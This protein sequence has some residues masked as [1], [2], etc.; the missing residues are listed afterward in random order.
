MIALP[1]TGAAGAGREPLTP[2]AAE[3]A[4]EAGRYVDEALALTRR[5]SAAG[6]G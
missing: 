4:Q 5:P 3:R 1:S 6:G 2:S